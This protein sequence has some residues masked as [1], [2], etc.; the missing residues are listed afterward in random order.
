MNACIPEVYQSGREMQGTWLKRDV[1]IFFNLKRIFWSKIYSDR[2]LIVVPSPTLHLWKGCYKDEPLYDLNTL[3]RSIKKKISHDLVQLWYQSP[4]S[5]CAAS[6]CTKKCSVRPPT[7]NDRDLPALASHLSI[8]SAVPP[9]KEKKK[10][11]LPLT[12]ALKP[13]LFHSGRMLRGVKP[14]TQA[15]A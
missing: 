15:E 9:F 10:K 7:L 14:W 12:F 6:S 2:K 1:G 11:W 4:I 13:L 5:H 8:W 3:D